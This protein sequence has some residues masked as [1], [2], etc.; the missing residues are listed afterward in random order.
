MSNFIGI[1][2]GTTN[3]AICSYD[4]LETQIHKS[5]AENDVTPS[6][7]YF[8]PRGGKQIGQGAYDIAPAYHESCAML[9]KRRMGED[10]PIEVPAVNR[11]FTPEECSV[12]IL[13]E[14]FGSLPEEIRKS[15]ETGTVVTFP[16]AF[17]QKAKNDT[18]QAAEMAGIGKVALVQEPVAAVMSFMH[19]VGET[20]GI[21]LIY[22]I[23]GGTFDV[24]IAQIIGRK[25]SILAHDGIPACGGRDFD[26]LIFNNIVLPLLHEEYDLPDDLSKDNTFEKFLRI[27]TYS[28]EQAKKELSRQEEVTITIP[29]RADWVEHLQD[30]KGDN[31][32]KEIL[33]QRDTF[34]KLIVE[35]INDTINC[36]HETMEGCGVNVHDLERIVWVGGP[37]YYKPLRDKVSSEL[38]IEGGI[39]VNVMTAVAEGASIF[40]ESIDWSSE[41]IGVKP[42]TEVVPLEELG[43]SFNYTAR[44]PN[45]RSKIVVQ[46]EGKVPAGYEFQVDSSDT[47]STSGQIPLKHAATVSVT[48]TKR[49]ENTFK[50]VVYDAMGEPIEQ[51]EIVITKTPTV[52]AIPAS[53][54]IALTILDKPG[55]HPIL[56][57]LVRK[58][59]PLPHKD[60]VVLETDVKV[61]AGSSN[62]IN[63]TLWE[64]EFDIIEDNEYIGDFK[65][66][67]ADFTEGVIP[68]GAHL[69]CNY[70]ILTSDEI[71]LEVYVPDI[72]EFF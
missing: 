42:I 3:S 53:S 24:A 52:D 68:I 15:A 41:N 69:R 65:I 60:I 55:G 12:E 16:A 51:N 30:L 38:G 5:R 19:R 34:D 50:I 64:G 67:G 22:D 13:K 45:D 46:V 25:V 26:R 57:Y 49:G 6:V 44:T 43:L 29:S 39:P 36:A 62:A 11:S 14:L 33:L 28:A 71:K 47:G 37:T 56:N 31:I 54:S 61:E 17:N 8:D 59:D 9:F 4:G 72:D 2:L 35:K 23:G 7:I 40:A 18:R 1:D 58:N 20:D 70:E 10:T 48:L 66:E 27:V 21:F 32:F 63:F